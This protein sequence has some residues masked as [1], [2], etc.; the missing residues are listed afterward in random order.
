MTGAGTLELMVAP[1]FVSHQ[2]RHS[3]FVQL[4]ERL[5]AE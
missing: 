3:D 2:W 4:A 1:T 5:R